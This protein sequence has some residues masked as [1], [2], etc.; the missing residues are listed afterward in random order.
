MAA[1]T[2]N[3]NRQILIGIPVFTADRRRLGVVT[4]ADPYGLVVEDG[5]LFRRSFALSL[6]DVE[7]AEDGALHLSLRMKDILEPQATR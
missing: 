1:T 3:R 4:E 2:L 5:F 7:C 6:R